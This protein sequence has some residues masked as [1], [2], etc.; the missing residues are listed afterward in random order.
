MSDNLVTPQPY[1]YSVSSSDNPSSPSFAGSGRKGLRNLTTGSLALFSGKRS[2]VV[3]PVSASTN[4]KVASG[5]NAE[6]TSTLA[7]EQS[8]V[9]T[10]RSG[11]RA[12][13]AP[14]ASGTSGEPYV[15]S[16]IRFDSRPPPL[17]TEQ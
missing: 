17:Y 7:A 13:A 10:M 5:S 9:V 8:H 6:G 14:S 16:G 15:D 11:T 12:S 1:P 2:E 4:E 3:E